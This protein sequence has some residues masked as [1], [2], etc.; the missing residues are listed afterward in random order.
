MIGL[1]RRT[2]LLYRAYAR[3]GK[4]P[5]EIYGGTRNEWDIAFVFA[6]ERYALDDPG[7]A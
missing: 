1:G 2:Y 6:A 7:A 4:T 3:T 5:S